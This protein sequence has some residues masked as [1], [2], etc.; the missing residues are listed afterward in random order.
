MVLHQLLNFVA[1]GLFR[2]AFD[3]V[4]TPSTIWHPSDRRTLR[5][6]LCC[7]QLASYK[8][9]CHS[10][11]LQGSKAVMGKVLTR[12]F[13]PWSYNRYNSGSIQPA[14]NAGSVGSIRLARKPEDMGLPPKNTHLL[15]VEAFMYRDQTANGPGNNYLI[16]EEAIFTSPS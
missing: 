12:P 14:E 4:K 2:I 9:V 5:L 7:C 8:D 13:D 11:T 16:R 10:V 1:S 3:H 15:V 6:M